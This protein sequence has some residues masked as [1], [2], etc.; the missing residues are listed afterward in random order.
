M[1][2][3]ILGLG[4]PIL[5]DD[6][7]GINIAHEIDKELNDPEVMVAEAYEG[8]LSLLDSIVNYDRVIIVDAIQTRNGKVG[9]VYRLEPADFSFSKHTSSPHTTSLAMALEL[10]KMLNLAIPQNISIFA[11]EVDDVS[12]FGEKCT[13]EV[14]KA[15]PEAVMMILSELNTNCLPLGERV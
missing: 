6:A 10:G 12:T 3:L 15:I 9:Q 13:C 7:V 14:E 11:V 1:K 4:N 5:S 8:G 2:T